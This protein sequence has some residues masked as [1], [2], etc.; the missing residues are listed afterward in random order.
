MQTKRKQTIVP[1]KPT[2]FAVNDNEVLASK[3]VATI[4]TSPAIPTIATKRVL[5]L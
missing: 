5:L 1:E 4:A 2:I 3:K